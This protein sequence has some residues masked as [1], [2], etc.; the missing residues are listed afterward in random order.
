MD[1]YEDVE[2]DDVYANRSRYFQKLL[3]RSETIPLPK[4]VAVKPPQPAPRRSD[5]LKVEYPK[6]VMT[7]LTTNLS[8]NI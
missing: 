1:R 3:S 2:L 8:Q 7:S 4:K 6:Q 5:I